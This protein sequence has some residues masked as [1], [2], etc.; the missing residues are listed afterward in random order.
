MERIVKVKLSPLNVCAK[1]VSPPTQHLDT[2]IGYVSYYSSHAATLRNFDSFVGSKRVV[3]PSEVAQHMF[4]QY[5]TSRP[6]Q[7]CSDSSGNCGH[8]RLSGL[9]D[10]LRADKESREKKGIPLFNPV[11]SV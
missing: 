3:L 10:L 2:P 4:P 5:D 6:C 11:I 8:I 7:H 9:I 1:E